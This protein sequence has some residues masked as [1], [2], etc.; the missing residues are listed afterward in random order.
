MKVELKGRK[1]AGLKFGKEDFKKKE[2]QLKEGKFL[3]QRKLKTYG[4]HEKFC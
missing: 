2:E 3:K 1:E 4:P